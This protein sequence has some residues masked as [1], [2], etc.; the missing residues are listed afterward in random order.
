MVQ[1]KRKKTNRNVLSWLVVGSWSS[2]ADRGMAVA[3]KGQQALRTR[4]SAR[5]RPIDSNSK[6]KCARGVEVAAVGLC[7]FVWIF[8]TGHVRGRPTATASGRFRLVACR[9]AWTL[10]LAPTIK[11]WLG[12]HHMCL[13]PP[14]PLLSITTPQ[15]TTAEARCQSRHGTTPWL[16]MSTLWLCAIPSRA[17]RPDMEGS[18]SKRAPNPAPWRMIQ[19]FTHATA[20]IRQRHSIHPTPSL[21]S[22]P[23][24]VSI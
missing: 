6:S 23:Q 9:A 18:V 14:P 2:Y 5:A 21:P 7:L 4:E 10:P 20:S 19:W 24:S 15:P 1:S 17:R 11:R 22:T 13:P 3:G 12:A 16:S 8:G